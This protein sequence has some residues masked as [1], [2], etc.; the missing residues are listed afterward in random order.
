ML[1][2]D[3]KEDW[4]QWTINHDNTFESVHC[5]EMVVDFAGTQCGN[6][7]SVVLSSKASDGQSWTLQDGAIVNNLCNTK[8]IDIQD[9][10]TSNGANLI[11]YSIHGN[12]NQQ[13]EIISAVV[14]PSM[15]PTKAP[16]TSA[17]T[18]MVR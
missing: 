1:L 18:P 9:G 5:P 17:P 7:V 2:Q 13:W 15:S 3:N 16:V 14:S 8:A 4:Q 11:L 10:S 12:W 6:L